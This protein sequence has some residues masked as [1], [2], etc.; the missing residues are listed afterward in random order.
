MINCASE[1][2][3]RGNRERTPLDL[4]PIEIIDADMENL[5]YAEE[6]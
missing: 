3:D 6:D 1:V 4:D 2:N 5:P